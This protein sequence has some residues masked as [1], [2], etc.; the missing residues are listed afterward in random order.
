MALNAPSSKPW[1]LS[2]RGCTHVDNPDREAFRSFKVLV[3]V[4]LGE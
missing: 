3:L 2:D 4:V 1:S